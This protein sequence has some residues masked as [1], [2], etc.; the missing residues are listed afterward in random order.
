MRTVGGSCGGVGGTG[1]QGDV[2]GGEPSAAGRIAA[3]V[4]SDSVGPDNAARA[5]ESVPLVGLGAG[6]GAGAEVYVGGVSC[7]WARLGLGGVET[8]WAGPPG[9]G[10][11]APRY[12]R[13]ARTAGWCSP[14]TAGPAVATRV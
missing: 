4:A 9:L 2:G 12:W 3:R 7:G 8:G 13:A 6:V 1:A 14:S 11:A 10:L 5:P